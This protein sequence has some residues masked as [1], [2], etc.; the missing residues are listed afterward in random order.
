MTW[1]TTSQVAARIGCSVVDL[2]NLIGN[3]NLARPSARF[4]PL[5]M[6]DEAD[7]QRARVALSRKRPGRGRPPKTAVREG[8]CR[9]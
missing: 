4:G 2:Y 6:W 8:V 1:S 9:V 5:L 3:R 7:V